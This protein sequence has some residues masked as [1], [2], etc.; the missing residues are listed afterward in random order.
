V[1]SGEP[2]HGQSLDAFLD[3]CRSQSAVRHFTDEEVP[4]A[5]LMRVLDAARWAPSLRNSQPWRFIVVREP[6]RRAELGAIF[7]A[8]YAEVRPSAEA[9]G[10]VHRAVDHLAERFQE[11]PAVIAACLDGSAA[12]TSDV[13]ARYGSIFP[14]I[15][16]LCLA[17]RAAGLGTVLTTVAR[18]Q[19]ARLRQAL[20][21]PAAV[22]V[23]AL[24][25]LGWPAHGFTSMRRRPLD[26]VVFAEAW[27]ARLTA[28]G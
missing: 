14:A 15:Q 4:E 20:G 27:Q 10:T 21:V 28:G 5:L 8:A 26:E 13:A 18:R 22:E 25:P 6:E 19:E 1:G 2:A 12:S 11:V 7:R 3:L 9:A 17:A 23:V 16:N 24:I